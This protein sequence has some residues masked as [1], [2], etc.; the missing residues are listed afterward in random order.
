MSLR[1]LAELRATDAEL[2]GAKSANL[3][4][5]IAAGLPVPPGFA[6]SSALVELD[7]AVAAWEALGEPPVAV[8]SSAI[9]EDG[10][11]ASFAGLQ[12]T[13]LWVEGAD[14]LRAA[15]EPRQP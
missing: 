1:P 6:L 4:E 14:A 5:L 7:E 11:E 13:Y 10:A 2:F 15:I 3:G 12:D 8:R 9:G